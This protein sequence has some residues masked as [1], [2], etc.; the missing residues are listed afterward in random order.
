MS[1]LYEA[2]SHDMP[3]NAEVQSDEEPDDGT[4]PADGRHQ[5]AMR[6]LE[7]LLRRSV[8]GITTLTVLLLSTAAHDYVNVAPRLPG[9][10]ASPDSR[11][12]TDPESA[13]PD[14]A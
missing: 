11:A 13:G 8:Y 1:R 2:S 5:E 4:A 9:P 14:G 3:L 6:T 12:F 7:R 10:R